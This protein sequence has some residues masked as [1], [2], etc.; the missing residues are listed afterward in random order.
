MCS[1]ELFAG[2]CLKITMQ[3]P[4]SASASDGSV[5]YQ[6]V[7][8][9]QPAVLKTYQIFNNGANIVLVDS[10]FSIANLKSGSYLVLGGLSGHP[11]NLAQNPTYDVLQ[12]MGRNDIIGMFTLGNMYIDNR[13]TAT[14][15]PKPLSVRPAY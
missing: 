14:I 13:D 12:Y 15:K 5:Q 2:G 10:S 11:I 9:T 3:H 4:S 6:L 8:I 7:G 1:N